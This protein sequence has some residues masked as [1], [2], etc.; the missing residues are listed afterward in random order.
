[1]L[2]HGILAVFVM[3]ETF[4]FCGIRHH[5]EGTKVLGVAHPCEMSAPI[6]EAV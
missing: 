1:M 6:F 2:G 3:T 4:Q 5:V